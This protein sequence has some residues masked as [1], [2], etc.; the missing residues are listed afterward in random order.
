M[1]NVRGV[2]NSVGL[3]G[4]SLAQAVGWEDFSAKEAMRVG[5]RV[6]NLIRSMYGRRGFQKSDEFCVTLKRLGPLPA[7]PPEG[8]SIEPFLP[9]MVEEYYRQMGWDAETGL[10]TPDTLQRLGMEEFL[11]DLP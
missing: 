2:K 10:P 3:T 1:F 6:T 5:E 4:R 7:G 8:L 9:A 11:E